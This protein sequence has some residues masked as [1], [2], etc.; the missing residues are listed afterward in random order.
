MDDSLEDGPCPVVGIGSSAGGIAALQSFFE[1]L[2]S[3]ARKLAYVVVVHL[4]PTHQSELAAILGTRTNMPVVQVNRRMSLEPGH[5]YVI[6]PDRRLQ[7]ADHEISSEEFSEPRG[8]RAPIDLFFR[9]L[10]EQRGDGFAVILTGAGSDGAVGV[11]AVKEAGGVVL[12]QDPREAEYPSMPRS[13]IATGVADFILPVREIAARIE[14]LLKAKNNLRAQDIGAF[15]QDT[16]HRILG[17]LRARTGHDF[18][19]YKRSTILRRVARRMQVHRKETLDEYFEFFQSNP[20]EAH[21]LFSDL[22]ISVTAFFRDPRA[23]EVL[24]KEAIPAVFEGKSASDPVRVWV[25]GCAT[26]EEAYS[27]AILLLEETARRSIRPPIQIFASDLDSAALAIARDGRFPQAIEADVSEERLRRFF[28]REGD[29]Y[30]IKRE[31]RDIILFASHSLLKDPP[32]SHLDMISCRNLLIYLDRELQQ[33]ACETF[34]Y[35]LV[36]GGYLFLGISE[37]A[38]S[39]AGLFEVVDRDAHLFRLIER[40]DHR[41]QL[42]RLVVAPLIQEVPSARAPQRSTPYLNAAF[43]WHALEEAAPPSALVNEAYTLVNLSE[44][45][46]R[47][48]L[49]PRGPVTSDITEVVRPELR[50]QLRTALHR[51]FEQNQSS[52][53]LPIAVQ[54]NGSA[55]QVYVHVQPVRRD[56][57]PP[58][59]LVMF[60]EGAEI[61]PGDA[62]AIQPPQEDGEAM[63][64]LYEELNATRT[65]LKTSLEEHES[66]SEELRAANEELQSINE[67]YRST[68]EELETSKEELQSVNEELQTVNNELKQKLE[69]VSRA[70]SDLQNLISATDVGTLFLD[71]ALQIKRFTPRMSDLFNITASDEGR[72]ITDFTHRLKYNGLPDDARRIL[73]HLGTMEKEVQSDRG[74]WFLMRIKPY[75]TVEDRIE[76]VVVTFVDVTARRKIEAELRESETRLQLARQAATIGILDYDPARETLWVDERAQ[77][78]LGLKAGT[79]AMRDFWEVVHSDDVPDVRRAVAL[80]LNASEGGTLDCEFRVRW[81]GKPERWARINGKCFFETIADTSKAVRLVITVHD[82][83]N[84]KLA[85]INQKLL[86]D[87]LS[88]RVKNTLSVVLAMARQTLRDRTEGEALRQLEARIQ[89]LG[90]AHDVLM[91]NQ[92]RGVD[93]AELVRAEVKLLAADPKQMRLSGPPVQLPP[94]L[95]TAFGTLVHEL[96]TNALKFGALSRKKGSVSI[97]WNL[98]AKAIP[99][100][101]SFRWEERDGPAVTRPKTD[102]FGSHLIEHGLPGAT[103]TR[104]FQSTGL[105]CQVELPLQSTE[106]ATTER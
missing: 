97:T 7:I 30:R 94:R 93:L 104:D 72:P 27:I 19:K 64:Q 34:A 1:S 12:V 78:I 43:H 28:T 68:A 76:G 24:T 25:A 92:W 9:S 36:P 54:F 62:A 60:I 57:A 46:G 41:V 81:V 22:L 67:E 6:A 71:T 59:A 8:R 61:A 102:G 45:A 55:R 10:A 75:R 48:L 52:L 56:D 79:L 89:A 99:P 83:S 42:P 23:F 31:V 11:R 101:L 80:A 38:D 69:G 103:V 73:D 20:E 47:F 86:L 88:Y 17:H 5:V 70:H 13:A 14:P 77:E 106:E 39:P 100:A 4:D 65:R 44:S 85:D 49:H 90:E 84:R 3:G 87:E 105:V 51:A 91:A 82:V 53:S 18:S 98:D 2:P 63:R 35:A 33:H 29:H 26:G 95:T 37:N 58:A 15:D 40:R 66:A 74:S 32:F 16:L 21:A 96:G 50:L